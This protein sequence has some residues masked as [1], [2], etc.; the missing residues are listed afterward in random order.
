MAR[1]LNA[2]RGRVARNLYVI[3]GF[4]RTE[5]LR[6]L[7]YPGDF[8]V[9]PLARLAAAVALIGFWNAVYAAGVEPGGMTREM[10]LAWAGAAIVISR[11]VAVDITEDI[12]ERIRRGDIV[13]EVMRPTDFQPQAFGTWA[14]RTGYTV[15]VDSL[16]IVLVIWGIARIGGPPDVTAFVLS[17][18]SLLL[19]MVIA[20]LLTFSVVLIGFWTIQVET[21]TWLLGRLVQLSAGFFV[22][23][24]L[25]PDALRDALQ[26]LPFAML[27]H[28][29]LSTFVGRVEGIEAWRLILVQ[30]AWVP[31]LFIISRWMMREARRRVLIQGG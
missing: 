2:D 15:L 28:V 1:K 26:Y 12:A 30:V 6:R 9:A 21:W 25:L 14:G 23:L 5:F 13:F 17:V 4:A 7:A 29:P 18:L 8:W 22:P 31:V 16:P 20:F 27:Y 24:W 10:M 19:S 11:L 3:W